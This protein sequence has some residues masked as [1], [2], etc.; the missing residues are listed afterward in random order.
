VRLRFFLRRNLLTLLEPV[1]RTLCQIQHQIKKIFV[2]YLFGPATWV[3]CTFL[4]PTA[5]L[6][7]P[8]APPNIKTGPH[9]FFFGCRTLAL[10]LPF[11]GRESTHCVLHCVIAFFGNLYVDLRVCRQ[12]CHTLDNS[13]IVMSCLMSWCKSCCKLSGDTKPKLTI[14]DWMT[15]P[16]PGVAMNCYIQPF[17]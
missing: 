2:F 13:T 14:S 7:H 3:R 1:G 11:G 17:S 8:T 15:A 16:A 10:R 12:L 5:A 9:P 4:R 6:S